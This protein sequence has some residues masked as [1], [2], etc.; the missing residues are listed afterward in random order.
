MKK[1]FSQDKLKFIAPLLILLFFIPYLLIGKI[2]FP[3]DTLVGL[4]HPFRDSSH[5]G[6]N[7]YKYPIKNPLIADPVLQTYPW[8]KITI[9]NLKSLSLP[10]W[11]PYNF[12]GQSH[13]ANVQAGTFQ[14]F[15]IFFFLFPFNIAW[16]LQIIT[17][18][19]LGG[20]FMYLFLRSLKLSE[21]SA[22]FGSIVFSFSGFFVSWLEWGTIIT[23][24]IWLPAILLSVN[25]ILEKKNLK[26]YFT[27]LSLAVFQLL[28]SGHL[29]T[30]FY[31]LIAV[32]VYLFVNFK[33]LRRKTSILL[34]LSF[35]IGLLLSAPQ[36]LPT[37]ELI[38]FSSRDIDQTFT[39]ERKDW[40][41]PYEN[42]TQLVA[43]DY[44]GNP[45]K[46]NY[47]GV[48][49]YGEFVSY[50]GIFTLFFALI[51]ITTKNQKK[52]FT[53]LLSLA[54]LFAVKNPISEFLYVQKLPLVSSMQPSRIIFL[55]GFC[56]SA[57]AAIGAENFINSK[58]KNKYF[59]HALTLFFLIAALLLVAKFK[60][61][62]YPALRDINAANVSFRNSVIPFALTAFIV[63]VLLAQRFFKIPLKVIL[64]LIF[65]LLIADLYRFSARYNTF[66]P[67]EVIYPDSKILSYLE[68]QQKPFRI[69]TTDRRVM[70]P[71]INAAYK[72]ESVD[73][74]DPL[75]TK[76]YTDF[77]TWWQQ[78]K[79]A[80]T[81][82]FNRIV[83]PSNFDSKVTDLLNVKYVLSLDDLNST[84][85]QKILEEGQ[86]KLYENKNYLNR[87]FFV[88]EIKKV[89]TDQELATN[90]TNSSLEIGKVSFSKDTEF[91][92]Q[93]GKSSLEI[94][95]YKE[96]EIQIATKLDE[97]KP[98]I[99]ST[100]Y[101]PGWQASVDGRKAQIEV[102]D[103]LLMSTIVPSG[104]HT[105]QF[106][107]VPKTFYN[108]L[109]IAAL[110]IMLYSGT[111][112]FLWRKKFQS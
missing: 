76:N 104:D 37:L 56:L 110:G 35:F 90:M 59:T 99:F 67:Q 38:N 57:M 42:L 12:A 68:N 11:N 45:T 53:I 16:T 10:L 74:Y 79:F 66:S 41:I 109:Y 50:V 89:E 87:T 43:P 111:M 86:T 85:L 30:A 39:S 13:I 72:I 83:V 73:G 9:D 78:E 48:F 46:N 5:L 2:P 8:R 36:I 84:K 20:F 75:Y 19:L 61:D 31:S 63:G 55:I 101:Y 105:V 33:L 49:H 69:M 64:V 93:A 7:Q 24:A 3:A 65:V 15:N 6:Y 80:Q 103:Y 18:L 94:T 96:N 52:Y 81:S 98:L 100:P 71:N 77:V 51:C 60:P 29:Q 95:S 108:G 97:D 44:L 62:I 22:I 28:V 92:T 106:K 102:V 27:L 1:L 14:I 21:Y 26:L 70:H 4:Y 23:T 107:F 32:V 88:D 34:V 91:K 40:F 58:T 25:K 47:W 82:S 17:P 112:I 54:V